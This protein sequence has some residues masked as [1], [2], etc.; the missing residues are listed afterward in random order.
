MHASTETLSIREAPALAE[1]REMVMGCM[2]CGTCGAS[3][4]N[5]FAMDYT[6][7]Q[8]W[9][10]LLLGQEQ[11]VLGSKTIYLCSSCYTCTVR[12]PRGLPLTEAM[13]ALK[14]LAWERLPQTR[15]R[16]AFYQAFVAHIRIYGRVQESALMARYFAKSR[17]PRLPLSF[18]AAGL[19]LL[20]K[21]KLHVP[22]ASHKGMLKGV[23]DAA[24]PKEGRT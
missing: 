16:A 18:T 12:C 23:V 20:R 11:E 10:L 2:Q 19:R 9:R 14:R 4:P 22:D 1:V 13:H 15:S 21:G 3:C 5:A 7:R 24:M 8:L 6:P 17:D